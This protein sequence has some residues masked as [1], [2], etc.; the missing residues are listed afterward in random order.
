MEKEKKRDKSDRRKAAAEEAEEARRLALSKLV[1]QPSADVENPAQSPKKGASSNSPTKGDASKKGGGGGGG[2]GGG[3]GSSKKEGGKSGS[4]SKK[5]QGGGGGGTGTD[6]GWYC[7]P[8]GGSTGPVCYCNDT[9]YKTISYSAARALNSKRGYSKRGC[10]FTPYPYPEMKPAPLT[11]SSP[12]TNAELITTFKQKP[13]FPRQHAHTY[14]PH[15]PPV[16]TD[17]PA[18]T[19]ANTL[20]SHVVCRSQ[21]FFVSR[22]VRY[23]PF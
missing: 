13:F 6:R 11:L 9:E 20:A 15:P 10:Y 8:L 16:F 1:K 4:S 2:G 3:N 12:P 5:G 14:T 18:N 19:L 17:T 22:L 21:L 23:G 7:Q